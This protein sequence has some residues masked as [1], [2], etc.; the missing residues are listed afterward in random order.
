MAKV[1]AHASHVFGV[2]LPATRSQLR[3]LLHARTALTLDSSFD[4]DWRYGCCLLGLRA[5]SAI[6]AQKR[7]LIAVVLI[8]VADASA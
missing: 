4:A 8:F 3:A 6:D 1:Q 2:E 7:G 5:S